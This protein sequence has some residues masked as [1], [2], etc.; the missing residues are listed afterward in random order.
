M[1]SLPPKVICL[2]LYTEAPSWTQESRVWNSSITFH[3]LEQKECKL[4]DLQKAFNQ[5][6][7]SFLKINSDLNKKKCNHISLPMDQVSIHETM[8]KN[9]QI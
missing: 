1:T 5:F 9:K 2:W 3:V 6:Q 8:K 7:Q 4:L